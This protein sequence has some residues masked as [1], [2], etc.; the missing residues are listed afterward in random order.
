MVSSTG[1]AV[2]FIPEWRF[3]NDRT[4][5]SP[6][7]EYSNMKRIFTILV[8]LIMIFTCIPASAYAAQSTTELVLMPFY[9]VESVE[10]DGVTLHLDE[11]RGADTF[12]TIEGSHTLIVAEKIK[13]GGTVTYRAVSGAVSTS[14][15]LILHEIV[16]SEQLLEGK[17]ATPLEY[18][19][20]IKELGT[21]TI[22][23]NGMQAQLEVILPI[24]GYYSKPEISLKNWLNDHFVYDKTKENVFYVMI[25]ED[26]PENI[27][28]FV[29]MN[30]V[31]RVFDS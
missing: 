8:C 12:M 29:A 6:R 5:V 27:D 26:Y 25:P 21:Y 7:P 23:Y 22:E 15:N 13:E 2:S 4:V 31:T 28:E 10:D 1:I 24:L 17:R 11:R 30:E 19:L 3:P 18:Q 9:Y 16:H 20:E 14:D